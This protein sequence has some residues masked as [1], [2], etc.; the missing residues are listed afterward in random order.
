MNREFLM[1]AKNYEEQT[2]IGWYM[3]EKIDGM[4]AFW[5]GGVSRGM[6]CRAVPYANT[7]KDS[8]YQVEPLATGLWSRYGHPIQA[9]AWFLNSLPAYPLDGEIFGVSWNV[10]VSTVKKLIPIDAE[11][12]LMT[13]HVFD[14][15][16]ANVFT[17]GKINNPNFKAF[18]NEIEILKFFESNGGK[19]LVNRYSPFQHSLDM[20]STLNLGSKSI[21]LPQTKIEDLSQVAEMTHK[22]VKVNKGEGLILRNPN[23]FYQ[24]KRIGD[25]LKLKDVNDMEG[26]VVGYVMGYGKYEKML[27]SLI[28]LLPNGKE[29]NLSGFT[30]S[31]RLITTEKDMTPGTVHRTQISPIFDLGSKVTFA[32][33]EMTPDGLPKEA[34]YVRY[35]HG[36]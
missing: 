2:V 25:L 29:F 18:F 6:S 36:E 9:P 12:E 3:S 17:A 19:F 22:V 34:R 35:R 30:D 5:D 10:T 28:I 16:T 7:A 11:W 15:P 31:E 27:G 24:P 21:L 20:L 26:T 33:R 8:R 4:R 14:S 13:Y 23:C 1:L 32:Y